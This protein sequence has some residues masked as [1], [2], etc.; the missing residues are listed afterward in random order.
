MPAIGQIYIELIAPI[1]FEAKK[2]DENYIEERAKLYTRF[3]LSFINDFCYP[4]G[5]IDWDKLIKFN[6]QTIG[7]VPARREGKKK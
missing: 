2:H 6:S 4:S 1:G 5:L 7:R 3:T